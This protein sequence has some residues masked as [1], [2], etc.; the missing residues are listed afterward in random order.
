MIPNEE[1][2]ISTWLKNKLNWTPSFNLE[3]GLLNTINYFK[4]LNEI[5]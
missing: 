1:I 5:N 4:K 3:S 2:L